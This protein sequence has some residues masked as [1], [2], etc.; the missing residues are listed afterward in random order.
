VITA[1]SINNR[2]IV[3]ISDATHALYRLERRSYSDATYLVYTVSG[4]TTETEENPAVGV[5]GDVLDNYNLADKTLYSYRYVDIA[6]TSPAATDY[7][8]SNWVKNGGVSATGYTFGNYKVADGTWGQVITEDDLRYTY[9]WG[10]DFKATNGQSFTDAQIKMFIDAAT[11]EVGRLLDITISKKKIRCDA[12]NRK[13]VKGTD[14]DV[15]ESVYDFKFAKISRYGLIK[16]RQRPILKLHKLELLSRMSG[17]KDCTST[18]IV[19]KTKGVLKLMERPLRPSETYSGIGTAVNPYGNQTLNAHLFY[20][21]DYDV[22][23]E[24]SDDIPMDLRQIIAKFAAVSLLNIIGDGL[25]S[26]FSSSSLSMDGISESFSST[27]S[28]TSAYFG[29]RIVEY[30]KDIEDYIKRNKYR[31]GTIA[32]GSL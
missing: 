15:E 31:F 7:T 26:G 9:L 17:I 10:T 32:I 24:T 23:F 12:V 5:A 8:Y 3:T 2:I 27:Q 13:L 18:T 21:I 29:A 19:D 28:A 22:G 4:F 14:Y 11:E 20:A 1:C 16:T 6:A 30:K 25:M